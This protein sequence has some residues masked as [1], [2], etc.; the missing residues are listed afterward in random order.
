MVVLSVMFSRAYYEKYM[1]IKVAAQ[2]FQIY[3]L[4]SGRLATEPGVFTR[5]NNLFQTCQVCH[6]D[7]IGKFTNSLQLFIFFLLTDLFTKGVEDPS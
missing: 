1:F 4:G 2:S 5:R 6:V 3:H 7:P